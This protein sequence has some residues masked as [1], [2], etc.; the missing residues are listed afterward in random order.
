MPS[1]VFE[2]VHVKYNFLWHIEKSNTKWVACLFM[3]RLFY[4]S[5]LV[6]LVCHLEEIKYTYMKNGPRDKHISI[7][8]GAAYLSFIVTVCNHFM[9]MIQIYWVI[10]SFR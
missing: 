2:Q 10:L 4:C 1:S 3:L 7:M 8:N 5:I 6:Q 9:L